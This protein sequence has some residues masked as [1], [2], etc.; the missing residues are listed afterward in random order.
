MKYT[1]LSLSSGMNARD[2]NALCFH[3]CK[4]F[5]C[6]VFGSDVF[7]RVLPKQKPIIFQPLSP[8]RFPATKA[9][10][11]QLFLFALGH[12]LTRRVTTRKRV[13]AKETWATHEGPMSDN[14]TVKNCSSCNPHGRYYSYIHIHT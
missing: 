11:V 6:A 8:R 12:R 7:V 2:F 13:G 4:R 1:I 9:R 14:G 5:L 3:E 10:F